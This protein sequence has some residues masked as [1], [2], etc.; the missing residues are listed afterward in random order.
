[1]LEE[2]G[3]RIPYAVVKGE[4][5]PLGRTVASAYTPEIVSYPL[6]SVLKELLKIKNVVLVNFDKIWNQ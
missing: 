4:I 5:S 2:G 6:G 3:V 1:M